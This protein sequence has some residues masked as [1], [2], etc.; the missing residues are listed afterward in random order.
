MP[1]FIVALPARYLRAAVTIPVA[2]YRDIQKRYNFQVYG[3]FADGGM[4]G[5][6][7]Q[8]FGEP[9]ICGIQLRCNRHE[10]DF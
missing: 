4:A 6:E 3:R 1:E 5:S 10:S 7:I 9:V 8:L 2:S